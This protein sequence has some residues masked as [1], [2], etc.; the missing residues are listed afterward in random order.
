MTSSDS[1]PA[2]GWLGEIETAL[3]MAPA[4]ILLLVDHAHPAHLR[5][6][7]LRMRALNSSTEVVSEARDLMALDGRTP[8]IWAPRRTEMAWMNFFRPQLGERRLVLWSDADTTVTMMREAPDFFDWIGLRV[9]CPLPTEEEPV[10]G[11][12]DLEAAIRGLQELGATGRLAALASLDRN[13]LARVEAA[14]RAGEDLGTVEGR[15]VESAAIG[16]D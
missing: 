10:A 8:T 5:A 7:Y 12:A 9:E 15:L 13:L 2:Q 16:A 1:A 11:R 3:T 4:K 14:L 6:L